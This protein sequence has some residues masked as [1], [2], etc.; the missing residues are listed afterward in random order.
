MIDN[1]KRIFTSI[2]LPE[3]MKQYLIS[4]QNHGVY[5]I[6]W[7][8]VKNFHITLN[9][10]GELDEGEVE[11]VKQVMAGIAAAAPC[12]KLVLNRC[13]GERDMLWVTAEKNETLDLL[14]W[15]L[16]T[17]FKKAGV[18]KTERRGYVPHIFLGKSKTGRHMSWLPKKFEPQE[19]AVNAINI[20]TSELTPGAATHRLI[21]SFP[22]YE[23][24][25]FGS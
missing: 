21:Q 22:L 5:W 25:G 4:L 15:R 2:D 18:G 3:S 16:K 13:R 9:F 7:M 10:L 20:Y 12:F 19:F 8:P 1:K 23:S 6:K 24:P 14:H 17:E 11:T